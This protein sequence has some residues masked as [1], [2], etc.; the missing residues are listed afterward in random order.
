MAFHPQGLYLTV[1]G[2]DIAVPM[3]AAPL[4]AIV[5]EIMGADLDL[6]DWA[7]RDLKELP[8]FYLFQT[9]DRLETRAEVS[10]KI[11]DVVLAVL[12][13]MAARRDA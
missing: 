11:A 6:V 5:A 13:R 4:G 8:H 7:Y 10:R 9:K 12:C 2:G 3:E 1:D